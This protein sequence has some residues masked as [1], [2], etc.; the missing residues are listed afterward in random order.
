M[1]PPP[2]GTGRGGRLAR[3]LAVGAALAGAG[4]LAACG[5]HGAFTRTV[6]S[7]AATA[8]RPGARAPQQR[9]RPPLSASQAAAFAADV[10][11]TAAD[12]PGFAV[13]PR[14]SESETPGERRIQLRLLTCIGARSE[15]S[16]GSVSAEHSSPQFTHPSLLNQGVSSSVSFLENRAA[17]AG[18]LALLRSSRSR[19]CLAHYLSELFTG[20][21]YG[22]AVVGHVIV[23]QGVPPA[24]GTTGGF[25]WRMRAN[26]MLGGRTLPLYID[27]LGF[28]YGPSEVR[29]LSSSLLIPFPAQAE[30]QLYQLLL[31]RA[32][33]HRL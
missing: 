6:T 19:R 22:K 4:S 32:T 13:H 7:P 30:E 23:R 20:R 17:G 26:V 25:A 9:S 21:H 28:I 1:S 2:A 3:L 27:T 5:G 10:N 18:Q 11:L 29:L 31:R 33:A 14:S 8:T 12:L 16:A 15:G 24:P